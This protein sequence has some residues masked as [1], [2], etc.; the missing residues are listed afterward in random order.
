MQGL[1]CPFLHNYEKKKK[2]Q[3]LVKCVSYKSK[4]N[5]NMI[6]DYQFYCYWSSHRQLRPSFIMI[7]SGD[8]ETLKLQQL[9]TFLFTTSLIL[10]KKWIFIDLTVNFF[11]FF[12]IN[13][14]FGSL[15]IYNPCFVFNVY[16][17][18]IFSSVCLLLKLHK[19]FWW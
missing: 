9:R 3:I 12:E 7:S 11:F 13:K 15:P 18:Q 19:K 4:V 2:R 17:I 16:K 6:I 10:K 1:N 14:V 5:L 8:N